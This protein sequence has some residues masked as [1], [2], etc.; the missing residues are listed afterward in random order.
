MATYD[1]TDGGGDWFEQDA[2]PANWWEGPPPQGFTGPWPPALPPGGSY[3]P[4]MGQIVYAGPTPIEDTP[5][6]TPPTDTT[7]SPNYHPENFAPPAP[8]PVTGGGGGGY[9]GP[10]A[11]TNT[12]MPTSG[13]GSAPA[14]YASDPNAPVFT[15]LPTYVAPTWEGG[16][17]VNP[18][19]SD[20]E[21]SVG[22]QSR[23]NDR[24]QGQ[25][26]RYAAGGTILNG[27]TVKALD[28]SAQDYATGEYQQLRSNSLDAYRQRYSQFQDK[29]GMDFSARTLNA[30]ENQNTYQN[31]AT[32]YL[33]GNNRTLSD[34]L[35]NLTAKRNA[36]LDYWSRLQDV[37]QTGAGAAGG[38]R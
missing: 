26:R 28:R 35:T 29:A 20:L 37:N 31:R 27:G 21:N 2:P 33:Q 17:F 4:N 11:T 5:G 9:R 13:Y 30:N 1:N 10:A 15:P 14:P 23:L 25:A 3:G 18:S 32:A 12:G 6:Y 19:Q 38:S 24:L 22:Y 36:E 8:A 34:Y 16:D 7:T